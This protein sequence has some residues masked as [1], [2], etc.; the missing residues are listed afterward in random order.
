MRRDD[1]VRDAVL[2]ELFA[3]HQRARSPRSASVGIRE[4]QS[5]LRTRGFKGAEVASNLDYLIQKGWAREVEEKRTFRTPRGTEQSASKVTY[6][7]SDVGIDRLA[8]ASVY[9]RPPIT[10]INITTIAGVTVVGDGNVVNTSLGDASAAL[11]DLRTLVL[12]SPAIAD[13]DRLE[14]VSDIDS[15]QAQLQKP[16]PSRE[17]VASLWDSVKAI[18]TAGGFV[19]AAARVAD[20][21]GPV[22]G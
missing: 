17:V 5:S 19:D 14:A 18:A 2:R 4:L 15:I 10:G 12:S 13:D 20:A 6:K 16:Q 8:G 22:L 1:E 3:A 7:I 21:L 11:A 9:Q